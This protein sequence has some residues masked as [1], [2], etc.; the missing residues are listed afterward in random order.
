MNNIEIE[1][2]KQMAATCAALKMLL[3]GGSEISH[4]QVYGGTGLPEGQCDQIGMATKQGISTLMVT[5]Q[6]EGGQALV[7]KMLL[8]SVSKNK[9]QL[10][11]SYCSFVQSEDGRFA[12]RLMGREDPAEHVFSRSTSR[13]VRR[14][15]K[16]DSLRATAELNGLQ[17]L[18]TKASEPTCQK[19]PFRVA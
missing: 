4:F 18:L 19:K 7:D 17:A 3:G 8:F 6:C 16:D 11:I 1:A 14:K 10:S 9:Q 15:V 2:I 13:L 12:L 5:F